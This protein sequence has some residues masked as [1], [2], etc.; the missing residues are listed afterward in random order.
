VF[1]PTLSPRWYFHGSA[2]TNRLESAG[3][4][5][6]RLAVAFLSTDQQI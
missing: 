3:K 2:Q 1:L 4:A 6:R 5:R